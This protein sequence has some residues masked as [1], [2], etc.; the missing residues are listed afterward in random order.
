MT[1]ALLLC[2]VFKYIWRHSS[3]IKC[4][5]ASRK[6]LFVDN[7]TLLVFYFTSNTH[8][9]TV[10]RTSCVVDRW[11][12]CLNCRSAVYEMPLVMAVG[13]NDTTRNR[14]LNYVNTHVLCLKCQIWN[15]IW[16]VNFTACCLFI[17]IDQLF[18]SC[19]TVQFTVII[20]KCVCRQRKKILYSSVPVMICCV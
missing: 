2:L 20:L 15:S 9:V 3:A 14:V 18:R 5:L 7:I 16:S 17:I 6:F 13:H 1:F 10:W 4:L 19:I 8:C 11:I 12:Y